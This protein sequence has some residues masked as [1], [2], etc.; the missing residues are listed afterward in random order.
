MSKVKSSQSSWRERREKK[1]KEIKKRGF[2]NCG[3]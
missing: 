1:D 3:G 2:G